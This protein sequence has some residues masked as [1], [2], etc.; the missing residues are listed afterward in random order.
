MI[1]KVLSGT[2]Y[3]ICPA[4]IFIEVN[5]LPGQQNFFIVG[6]PDNAIKESEHR[7]TSALMHLGFQIPKKRLI[8]N[9]APAS[10]RKGGATYDLAIALAILNASKQVDFS[11]LSTF[12]IVGELALD[13]KLRPVK[14]ILPIVLEAKKWGYKKILLPFE[15]AHQAG[16]VDGID[17]FPLDH[18]S[19]TIAYLSREKKIKPFRSDIRKVF[20]QRKLS[21]ALNMADVKGQ[22]MAK[23]ALCIAAAGGHNI[24]LMGC[25]GAGKTMLAKRIVSIL[26]PLSFEEALETSKIYSAVGKL[27]NDRSLLISPPF[28]AP[29]HTISDVAMVGGGS[30]PQPGE[31]SLAQNGILFLDEFPEFRRSTLEVLRQPLQEKMITI[32]RTKMTLS[33]PANF[34]LIASMNPCPCGFYT[35]PRKVCL[36]TTRARKRY[37]DKISGPLLDRID[38]HVLVNPLSRQEL[39]EIPVEESS[40]Y[41]RK[42]VERARLIQGKRYKKFPHIHTNSMMPPGFF[43]K[44]IAHSKDAHSYLVDGVDKKGLSAR[45]Y[46]SLAAIATTIADLEGARVV[47]VDH[48]REAFFLR[49]IEQN[50]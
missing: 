15:N 49:N 12:L 8:V 24:L 30:I 3:G 33:L 46:Q 31:V 4:L 34:I 9:L 11:D 40:L 19:S 2:V 50:I 16:V 27:P 41:F 25:P 18:L 5:I 43:A 1:T 48:V 29:H 6:L 42:K 47:T 44:H 13:G 37:I 45:A 17:V 36:C 28:R 32:T 21:L 39:A 10:L 7:I 26:P 22:K 38:L 20:A 23:R 35:H 14:G